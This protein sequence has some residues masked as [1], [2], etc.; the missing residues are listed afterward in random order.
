MERHFTMNSFYKLVAL[1]GLISANVY[2]DNCRELIPYAPEKD[3]VHATCD[4]S[5]NVYFG[6]SKTNKMPSW[7][8]YHVAKRPFEGHVT[9]YGRYR[10]IKTLAQEEQADVASYKSEGFDKAYL[11]APYQI[12]DH[13]RYIDN[14]YSLQNIIPI[15]KEVWRDNLKTVLFKMDML[16]RSIFSQKGEVVAIYGTVNSDSNG[17]KQPEYLYRVYYQSTYDLT[18]AY[19][20][21]VSENL[22]TEVASYITPIDCIEKK[23]GVDLLSFLSKG[24][25][26]DIENRAAV[27]VDTWARRDGNQDEYVCD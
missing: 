15:K 26:A 17:T 23:A 6:Y 18:I 25:Q 7:A 2:A 19:L 14:A 11:V 4:N 9:N 21:P 22:N 1:A 13:E 24:R 27:S 8:V 5:L 3:G 20:L 12:I 10:P 16:E